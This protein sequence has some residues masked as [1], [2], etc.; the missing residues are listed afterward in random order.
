[1]L[2]IGVHL[3]FTKYFFYETQK[4]EIRQEITAKQKSYQQIDGG[5]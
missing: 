1:M 4:Q 3:V 2:L 5:Q